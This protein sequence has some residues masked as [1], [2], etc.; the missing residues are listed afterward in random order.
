MIVSSNNPHRM[1]L[2]E[3]R[4]EV[5]DEILDAAAPRRVIPG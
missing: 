3:T 5:V 4:N 1:P 2:S